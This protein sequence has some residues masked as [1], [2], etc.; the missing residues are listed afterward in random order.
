MSNDQD[1]PRMPQRPVLP[2][3]A[4]SHQ[5]CLG[6]IS[7]LTA[8][9]LVLLAFATTTLGASG[10][11]LDDAEQGVPG[12]DASFDYV[13]VGAGAGGLTLAARLAQHRYKVALVE[14]GDFYEF[15]YPLAAV[16]GAGI[17]GIGSDVSSSTPVDWRFVAYAVPGA[18]YR[19]LHYPRGKCLGGSTGSNMMVYQR[20]NKEAM[21]KWAELVNDDSYTFDRVLPFF[22][23]TAN[24]T[25]PNNDVRNSNATA[26]FNQGAFD[27]RGE[28][29]Q[30]SYPEFAVPFSS[31]VKRGMESVGIPEI[32]DFNSGS[33]LGAQ[34]CAL[35]I[36]PHKKIRSS[37]EA[38]F[39]SSPIPRLM[40]LAVYKKT[41][42]KRILFNIE[43][44]ATGVEVRT[45]G[46]KYIL[47]A[48]REVI[49]S[50]GAF[51]SPQLLM[52]SGI[53]PA[54]ELKQHG[55]EIIVDLP[56][57]GKNMWDHVFFGPAYRVAL[58][59]STRIATDFLYL[60][61]VIVQYLSNHSGPLSTQGIDFLAFE[62]VPIELRSHFSEETIRDLSWFPPGWPEIEYIPVAL[63]LGD[64]SDPIKHQPLDGA[65]YASI[66]GAL[67]AP[68]SR[69]NVTIISDDT[70]DLPII[71]P[72]WL[73]TDTDQEVAI[74][75]YRRNREIFHSAGMEP[76]IDG[77]E[78]FPG[79]ELQTD[80]EILEVVKDTL[81]TVYH[82]SCTC[83]MGVRNDSMAVVD[84][85]AR[86]FGVD[87]L[88]VVDASAFP[89]LPP[90]HPQSVVYMLAEKIAS[91]IIS[92]D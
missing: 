77:E 63:Y 61:E 11:Y 60:T 28:P 55:I 32:Q 26:S 82:A 27:K 41:M 20:P 7:S 86:V 6:R 17:I 34:Y 49:V 72:N 2:P 74:A 57:V 51:Q 78:Y 53:G 75:I 65:Q 24:F 67:V 69:G 89:I 81:M 70:D 8:W 4:C 14:A 79:E 15:K 13:V 84:S 38:A 52:V 59:T 30:V 42:A 47:R 44:R 64:F 3:N 90:G 29:L 31:W 35:T 58:P 21:Q 18:N 22:Q 80:S 71:N 46:S 73:A 45:G 43:R 85:Q 10:D 37:S 16:P 87:G 62:K 12:L 66:A 92:W 68:T 40:T 5:T 50:A 25:P 54:N 9:I 39:K 33:L 36:D 48:T 19:D 91:D 76:I 1:M 83:K 88:R 56:G 23:R